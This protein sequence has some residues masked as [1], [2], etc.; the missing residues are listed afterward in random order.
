MKRMG[1]VSLA[2]L[3]VVFL[4]S[5]GM[6]GHYSINQAAIFAL[7][8]PLGLFFYNHLDFVAEGSNVPDLRKYS[9]LKDRNEG[10][11]HFIDIE[12]FGDIAF[13]SL[14]IKPKKAFADK[15]LQKWGYLPWFVMETTKSLTTAMKGNRRTEALFIASDLGHYIAD[16]H[17]PLHTSSNFD[18]QLT[19]QKGVHAHWE[20]LLVERYGSGYR[21]DV[22]PA[23]YITNMDSEIW[24]IIRHA[25]ALADSMLTI[26]KKL[27]DEFPADNLYE[28]DA[29]GKI[30]KNKFGQQ[31]FSK[32]Y[33]ERYHKA[34]NGMVESQMR[35]SIRA[36]ANFWYTAWVDAGKPDLLQLDQ[37][38]LTKRNAKQYRKDL[39]IWQ[40]G[41]LPYQYLEKEY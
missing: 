40:S 4:S 21:F 9:H 23:Q 22:E 8:K 5:W 39:K 35:K 26:D 32:E 6:R 38:N 30:S 3:F 34:L 10:P 24:E 1:V 11:R 33:S 25:H 36:I 27:R 29:E 12:D 20:A 19:D 7:P 16:A 14:K 15:D 2:T 37:A 28:K 31:V 18:G 17:M 41:K 13:D